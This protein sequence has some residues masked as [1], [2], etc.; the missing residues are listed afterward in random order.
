MWFGSGNIFVRSKEVWRALLQFCAQ[1]RPFVEQLAVGFL[2]PDC[3]CAP[4]NFGTVE[5]I[6]AVGRLRVHGFEEGG[7]GCDGFC[8]RLKT[9]E[10]RVM[11]VAFGFAAE[12]FLRQQGLAPE[13]DEAFGVEIFRVQGPESHGRI[14]MKFNRK[15]R[16]ERKEKRNDGWLTPRPSGANI[17]E[18]SG[19]RP[20]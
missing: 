17:A 15:E 20:V 13:S 7:D 18:H 14:V 10:L 19:S 1:V 9:E 8:V 4:G 6:T 11:A 5:G 3:L 16:K 2:Q 12:N